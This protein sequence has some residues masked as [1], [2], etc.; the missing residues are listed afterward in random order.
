MGRG[1]G[2]N[3]NE[4]DADLDS[5]EKLIHLL[6]DV[7]SKNGN[8]LLNVGPL[9]NGTI[10]PEQASRLRDIGAWLAVNGDAIFAS[11][12]WTRAE[13][14]AAD[15]TPVRFTASGDGRTVYAIVM[16]ALPAGQLTIK[17]VNVSPMHVRLLGSPSALS[18]FAGD[19]NLRI[20]LPTTFDEQPAY[21]F[22]LSF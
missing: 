10:P 19:G 9:A 5:A 7:V 8:L 2:Y 12:P 1:F 4:S 20:A 17:D 22:A 14:T 18:A 13:G 16:G 21:V 6:I 11:R 15:G 3:R